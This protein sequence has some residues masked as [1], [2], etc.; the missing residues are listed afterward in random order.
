MHPSR[1]SYNAG[2]LL[3][4]STPGFLITC[5]MKRELSAT[6]EASTVLPA[7]LQQ[8]QANNRALEHG[9]ASAL[10]DAVDTGKSA[11]MTLTLCGPGLYI[12]LAATQDHYAVG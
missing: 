9:D 7:Y 1:F 3:L 6:K 10:Q 4:R 12:M 5:T 11:H 2:D 8:A